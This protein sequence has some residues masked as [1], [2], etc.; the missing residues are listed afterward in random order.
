MNRASVTRRRSR[1][2]RSA[3]RLSTEW[4]RSWRWRRIESS[5]PSLIA[6]ASA[7]A[8]PSSRKAGVVQNGGA[9]SGRAS[10]ATTVE[11]VDTIMTVARPSTSVV[12][13][14]FKPVS[15]PRQNAPRGRVDHHRA[16][17][18][19][20]ARSGGDRGQA[21]AAQLDASEREAAGVGERRRRRTARARRSRGSATSAQAR[22]RRGRRTAAGRG[23]GCSPPSPPAPAPARRA[24]W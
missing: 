18:A 20:H 11:T 6:E 19:G 9:P 3:L 17:H 14:N 24:R 10:P 5:K 21:V 15:E 2:I 16:D 13:P 4:W 12:M 8:R 7:S 1:T 23:A 22:A